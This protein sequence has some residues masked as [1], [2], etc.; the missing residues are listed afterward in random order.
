MKHALALIV[1]FLSTSACCL[2]PQKRIADYQ[3]VHT[4]ALPIIL[5]SPHGGRKEIPRIPNPHLGGYD[6]YTLELT[7]LI[8]E[9][10]IEQTGVSPEMVAMLADRAFIDVNREAGDQAYRHEFT[11]RLYEAHYERIDA[12]LSRVKEKQ[13]TGLMVLIHSGFD[14]PVQIAIGVNH[15]E[16]TCT[17]PVFV[18]KHGW[19]SFHG[20]DGVGGRLFEQGYEVAGFGGVTGP[21]YAGVPIL[22]RCRKQENIGIDGLQFEFQGR[23]LLADVEKRQKLAVDVADVL[24]EFVD[25]YYTE[26]PFREKD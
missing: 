9:R 26:I 15:Y 8:R 6:K 14:Y 7:R 17:I 20:A 2:L 10:M 25:T 23:T 16:D 4:G 18:Q 11:R 12:A 1:V 13:G 3:E 21:D 24:L 22:T 19:D 5:E